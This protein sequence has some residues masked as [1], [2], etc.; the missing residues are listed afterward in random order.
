M[1]YET[2]LESDALHL[3]K[4]SQ[5]LLTANINA[6]RR[7][8]VSMFEFH[9]VYTVHPLCF[10]MKDKPPALYL[11]IPWICVS[12]QDYFRPDNYSYRSPN[13]AHSLLS[14]C[15]LYHVPP[16][17][18]DPSDPEQNCLETRPPVKIADIMKT[19]LY[20]IVHLYLDDMVA[21][22]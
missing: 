14:R 9:S 4:Y 6:G 8:S 3:R 2:P 21:H 16:W 15:T 10:L 22:Q 1:D 17:L 13:F 12:F 19:E 11:I 5:K 20:T 18:Y 7:D